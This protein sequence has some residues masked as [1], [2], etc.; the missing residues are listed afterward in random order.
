MH[1]G[2]VLGGD[3]NDFRYV[4]ERGYEIFPSLSAI[5]DYLD[6]LRLSVLLCSDAYI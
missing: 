5:L 6:R 4:L 1:D 2:D 3:R